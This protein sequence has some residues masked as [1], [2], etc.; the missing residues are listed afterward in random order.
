M[1][2][3]NFTMIQGFELWGNN[4]PNDK[5]IHVHFLWDDHFNEFKH[6]QILHLPER[7]GQ[8][9]QEFSYRMREKGAYVMLNHPHWSMLSS[10]EVPD[11]NP[12]HAVEIMKQSA[13]ALTTAACSTPY[14]PKAEPQPSSPDMTTSM[15]RSICTKAS[16][17]SI[18]G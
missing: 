16:G 9:C 18:T 17:S 2:E 7:T 11:E 15:T 8:V 6:G 4:Y 10:P 13:A 1:S 14:W 12:Y 3:E 5:D